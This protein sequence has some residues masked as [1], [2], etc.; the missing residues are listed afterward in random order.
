MW[1]NGNLYYWLCSC[2]IPFFWK[3]CRSWDIGQNDHGHLDCGIFKLTISPKEIDEIVSFLH[4]HTN[5]QKLKV[6]QTFCGW[7][8]S[9]TVAVMDWLYLK[10][11]LKELTDFLHTGR[12]SHK[13][14]GDWKFL[15]WAWSKTGVAR[16]VTGL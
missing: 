13:L 12:I 1:Y 10:N 3:E 2:T 16:L 6:D 15:G 9:K 7:V 8:W 5:S 14:K 4:V 11:E